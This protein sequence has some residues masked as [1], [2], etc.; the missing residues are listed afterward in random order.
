MRLTLIEHYPW[1][2][3]QFLLLLGMLGGCHLLAARATAQEFK[4]EPLDP[5]GFVSIFDGRTLDGWHV[6]AQTGHSGASQHKS[7]GRWVVED[8]AI[9]GSQDTPGNGGIVLTDKPY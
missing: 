6:S 2:F 7:G 9:T 3:I 1:K 8:G 4:R 5:A